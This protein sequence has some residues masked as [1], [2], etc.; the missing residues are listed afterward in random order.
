MYIVK[1]LSNG[2]KTGFVCIDGDGNV[3]NWNICPEN[4]ARLFADLFNRIDELES[5][6]NAEKV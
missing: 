3:A 5:H 2:I 6:V 4:D 1:E